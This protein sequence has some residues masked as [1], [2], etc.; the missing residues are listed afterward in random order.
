M[1]G[2]KSGSG[3]NPT[4]GK[5]LSGNPVTS[6]IVAAIAIVGGIY[7]IVAMHGQTVY[8][9]IGIFMLIGGVYLIINFFV[10]AANRR[11]EAAR[12]DAIVKSGKNTK[13][14]RY[15]EKGGKPKVLAEAQAE[16]YRIC[17][18]RIGAV[19]ELVVNGRVY[20]EKRGIFEFAHSLCA[21]LDGHLIE[22]GYDIY[23]YSYIKFDGTTLEYKKRLY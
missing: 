2:Q 6:F 17:Y 1:S 20:D 3:K 4:T 10:S 8:T 23:N 19:N 9:A 15:A 14:L 12:L 13:P 22:V 5:A 7:M 11:R 21:Y 18:R 16:S